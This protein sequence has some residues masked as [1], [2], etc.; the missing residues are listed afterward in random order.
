MGIFSRKSNK[1]QEP[2]VENRNDEQ[3][4]PVATVPVGLSFLLNRNKYSEDSVSAF[5]GALELISNS[6]AGVPVV[7]RDKNT[8]EIIDNHPASGV[9]LLSDI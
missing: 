7:V 5:W 3:Q 8:N 2:I 1:I 4:E 6:L 9:L